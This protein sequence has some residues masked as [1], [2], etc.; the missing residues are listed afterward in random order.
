MPRLSSCIVRIGIGGFF[1]NVGHN[2][3][4]ALINA[5]IEA[6]FK[7]LEDR[8]LVRLIAEPDEFPY[9]D[10]YLDT[11]SPCSLDPSDTRGMSKESV[12]R[13]KEKLWRQIEREGVWIYF[14]QYRSHENNAWVYADNIG[15]IIGDDLCGYDVG[16]WKSAIDALEAEWQAEANELNQRATYAAG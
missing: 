15:G 7:E 16:L 5:K 6:R 12:K 4:A 13:A 3:E 11:R 9:D 14:A 10:S 2:A 8:G 1:Y